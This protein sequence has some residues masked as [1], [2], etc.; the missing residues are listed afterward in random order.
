MHFQAAVRGTLQVAKIVGQ[1]RAMEQA[2]IREVPLLPP[3]DT[4][5]KVFRDF[6]R[7]G[8]DSISVTQTLSY[9][10]TRTVYYFSHWSQ[11]HTEPD[12]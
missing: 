1:V 9:R 6:R 2:G 5:R 3:A 8:Y 12:I 7:T 4:Q 10:Q 11:H